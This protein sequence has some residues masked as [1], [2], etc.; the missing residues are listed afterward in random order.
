MGSRDAEGT[1]AP[2]RDP[3]FGAVSREHAMYHRPTPMI[4]LADRAAAG[5]ARQQRPLSKSAHSDSRLNL[6]PALA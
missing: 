3:I 6:A 5:S 1:N 4:I 2:R